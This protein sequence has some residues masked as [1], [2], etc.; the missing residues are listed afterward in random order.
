M[1]HKQSSFSKETSVCVYLKWTEISVLITI[2]FSNSEN[3]ESGW[4][5]EEAPCESWALC[6]TIVLSLGTSSKW[7]TI[8]SS[9]RINSRT[10]SM[11]LRSEMRTSFSNYITLDWD[12][13]QHQNPKSFSVHWIF[14]RISIQSALRLFTH[15][16]VVRCRYPTI[17]SPLLPAHD[18][19]MMDML[20]FHRAYKGCC[21]A[22]WWMIDCRP[23]GW[24]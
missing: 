16:V 13:D 8:S 20:L 11:A 23:L 9:R 5:T 18:H 14:I 3:R 24:I 22:V 21:V 1:C 4:L 7:E 6:F 17:H 19:Q 15:S 12:R 2:R 10:P